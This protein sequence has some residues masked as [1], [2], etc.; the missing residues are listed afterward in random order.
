MNVCDVCWS[1]DIKA[2]DARPEISINSGN[3]STYVFGESWRN[4][5]V[6]LCASC[7][8]FMQQRNWQG[9]A[10]AARNAIVQRLEKP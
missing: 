3:Q 2:V 8:T 10:D 9:L 7:L 4:A 5:T 1:P 6:D